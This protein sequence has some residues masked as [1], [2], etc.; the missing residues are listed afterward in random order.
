LAKHRDSHAG[1]I[2][3]Q[4]TFAGCDMLS[5]VQALKSGRPLSMIALKISSS[6]KTGRHGSETHTQLQLGAMPGTQSRLLALSQH[7]RLSRLGCLG[8]RLL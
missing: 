3:A 6:C 8:P 1:Y 4:D 7:N 5:Q 2:K